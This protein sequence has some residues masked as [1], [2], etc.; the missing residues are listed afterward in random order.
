MAT[1]TP[2]FARAKS[3]RPEGDQPLVL[4]VDDN[5]AVREACGVFCERSGFQVAQASDAPEALRKAVELL[6]KAIVLDLM[7]P[8][9][10]GWDVA[11]ALRADDR[12]SHIPILATSGLDA[13]KAE[14]KA[15]AAGADGYV[16][17]P[18]DGSTLVR[19]IRR[20]LDA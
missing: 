14:R 12:T 3:A 10:P 4:I 13:D 6:P 8:S 16:A 11:R 7:L 1:M 5:N 17:K 9:M 18:F 19:H 20:L 2:E 15:R